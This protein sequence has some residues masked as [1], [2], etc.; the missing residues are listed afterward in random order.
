MGKVHVVNDFC[1]YCF[2]HTLQKA[3]SKLFFEI[4]LY[5]YAPSESWAFASELNVSVNCRGQEPFCERQFVTEEG[6][7]G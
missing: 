2:V 7:L 4:R 3:L 5:M 1:D 6:A